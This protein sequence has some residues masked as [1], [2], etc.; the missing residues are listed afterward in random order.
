MQAQTIVVNCISILGSVS[1][2]VL[3]DKKRSMENSLPTANSVAAPVEQT[4]CGLVGTI[5]PIVDGFDNDPNARVYQD[6]GLDGLS[7]EFELGFFDTTYLE[8]VRNKF[9][10]NVSGLFKRY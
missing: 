1:E 7:D 4:A 8:D 6:V 3:P 9:G 2:D 5:Q 10:G